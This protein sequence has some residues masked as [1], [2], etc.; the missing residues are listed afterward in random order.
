MKSKRCNLKTVMRRNRSCLNFLLNHCP[1]TRATLDSVSQRL[2]S[3]SFHLTPCMTHSISTL[4]RMDIVEDRSTTAHQGRMK[5]IRK[6]SHAA[7]KQQSIQECIV[8]TSPG[9]ATTT[10]RTGTFQTTSNQSI[11]REATLIDSM[12]KGERRDPQESS[13]RDHQLKGREDDE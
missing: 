1:S 7:Q 9:Q 11:A 3:I 10:R 6:K 8:Q 13:L 5:G 12:S 2:M 4:G